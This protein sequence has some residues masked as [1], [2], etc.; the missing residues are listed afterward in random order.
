MVEASKRMRV[1]SLFY[2]FCIIFSLQPLFTV[3]QDVKVDAVLDTSVMRI[4]EQVKID[5]Y[6]SYSARA[7]DVKIE[8]PHIGDTLTEKVEVIS[9]STIDTTLPK[10]SNSPKIFQHQQITVSVY[11]SGYYAIP[12]F[13]FVVNNDSAHPVYT[14]PLLLEVHTVPT[15]TSATKIKDIKTV[16]DEPFNWKWY[17]SYLYWGLAILLLIGA[18]ILLTIYF[19]RKKK[20]PQPEIQKP[21]IPPHIVA[22]KALDRVKEEQVWKEGRMKEYYSA[23]SDT[24]RLYIEDRFQVNALESTTD[25]IMTA[26]RSQ[27]IDDVSRD[28]LR[29]LLFLSDLVKFAKLMPIENE[30]Q[31]TLQSAYDFVNGTKREEQVEP[32]TL[33]DLT[34]PAQQVSPQPVKEEKA[35]AP[36]RVEKVREEKVTVQTEP[37]PV[38]PRRSLK[39]LYIIIGS[40]LL[41]MLLLLAANK[42]FGAEPGF[43]ELLEQVSKDMNR[44]C[45][46]M[47]DRETRLD[48]TVVLPGRVFQYNYTL[49][50]TDASST[51]KKVFI[52]RMEP[53][54]FRNVRENPKL[55]L[56]RENKV[57]MEYVYYDRNGKYLFN[58]R[59]KPEDY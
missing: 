20:R 55:A 19:S 36:Q 34:A 30:H 39:K 32:S 33:V 24:I 14:R 46:M 10:Q 12:G 40:A 11:D 25:E 6:V 15:D 1:R 9:V 47:V 31:L 18:V 16:L 38:K 42:Y 3:A 7:G 28:K 57:T 5:V 13:R 45:P 41:L 44:S 29:Q 22:L 52:E 2:F 37:E 23:I 50:R 21:K 35:T 56:Q 49:I 51:D 4:G 58:I 26:F 48:S 54:I 8:W 53:G 17:L 43:N 59:V 27:V